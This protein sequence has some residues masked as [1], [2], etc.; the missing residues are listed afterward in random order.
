MKTDIAAL[1]ASNR[2]G[3]KGMHGFLAEAAEAGIENARN[4]V[5]GLD[6]KSFCSAVPPA[7]K[8]C[9]PWFQAGTARPRKVPGSLPP[10]AV[11]WL[12]LWLL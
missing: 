6:A 1:I 10:L 3:G 4:L 9:L 5:K 11:Y 12:R 7:S 2:G 8:Y